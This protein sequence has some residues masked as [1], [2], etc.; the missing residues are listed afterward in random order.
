MI[1]E[2]QVTENSESSIMSKFLCNFTGYYD[3]QLQQFSLQENRLCLKK[4]ATNF[5]PKLLIVS[6]DYYQ[7]KQLS[8]PI[9]NRKELKK[10]LKLQL[11]QQ[12]K[13]I[14][15]NIGDNQSQVN[16]WRFDTEIQQVLPKTLM[17]L[18]E[19][20]I[21]AQ[22][23][24][25]GEVITLINERNE[26]S[27]VTAFDSMVYSASSKGFINSSEKFAMSVG[28][29][30]TSQRIVAYQDKAQTIAANLHKISLSKLFTFIYKP[31]SKKLQ[32][33]TLQ[34]VIPSVV[35][36]FL[37]LLVTSGYIVAK[38]AWL[39]GEL[40]AQS[41]QVTELFSLQNSVDEKYS[42]YQQLT[43]FWQDKQNIAGLWQVVAPI[44][45][46]A[47]MQS[48]TLRDRRFII[49][50]RTKSASELLELIANNPNVSNA[51]FEAPVR[52]DRN[53]ERFS[54]SFELN[55]DL[56][57]PIAINDK[58]SQGGL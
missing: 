43:E 50:G 17:I 26:P 24:Q 29:S 10:L 23:C 14:I 57:L 51:K 5:K 44:F 41:E 55:K 13:A 37:Y 35:A 27:Y 11:S 15:Q 19:S 9:D 3:G 25:N 31:A 52:I 6:A 4:A 45:A 53:R 8:F 16:T 42:N 22:N 12:E 28:I 48:I 21:L 49:K 36:V 33:L 1:V 20:L 56:S 2:N 30:L 7:E 58:Q 34:L 54:L 32:L 46:E 38:S 47:S 40:S 39:E 18:P